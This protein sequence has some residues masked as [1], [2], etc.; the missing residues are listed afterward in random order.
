KGGTLNGEG[1]KKEVDRILTDSRINRFVD[2]F[3]RQW[4][5]LHRV[6]TFPPDKKLYPNYDRWLAS[7]SPIRS[8]HRGSRIFCGVRCQMTP[9]SPRPKAAP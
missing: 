9:S 4:L 6:G 7:V 8:L 5:Q 2:D 3:S 1:L